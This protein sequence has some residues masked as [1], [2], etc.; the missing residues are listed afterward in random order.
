MNY[1]NIKHD[2]MMNGEGLRVTLFVSGCNHKCKNCHNPETHNPKS[3]IEFTYDDLDEILYYLSFDYIDGLTLSGGDPLY[4]S[5]IKTINMIIDTVKDKLP[6]KTIWL[7]TGYKFEQILKNN[8]MK[9]LISKVDILVDGKYMEEKCDANYP[10]AGSTNQRVIDV[11]K[12]L[13]SYPEIILYK[14]DDV[15]EIT[16]N[17]IFN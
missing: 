1:H 15:E 4:K 17:I 8:N 11:K 6:N 12:S 14:E 16:N 7:Y 5:N 2:D 3:G 10:W 13:K 9:D